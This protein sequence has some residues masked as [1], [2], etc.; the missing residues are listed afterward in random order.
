MPLALSNL[1]RR[2]AINIPEVDVAARSKELLCDS[3]KSEKGCVVERRAPI[4]PLKIDF[5]ASCNEL[6]RD[7]VMTIIGR[8]V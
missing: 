5:T 3:L 7:G 1:Q 6:L 2:R 8:D 4:F